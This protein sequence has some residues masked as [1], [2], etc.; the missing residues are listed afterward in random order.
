MNYRLLIKLFLLFI[1]I[2]GCVVPYYPEITDK[3]EMI[4]IQGLITDQPGINTVKISKSNPLWSRESIKYFSGFKVWITDDEG[5]I[6]SLKETPREGIY[7]T[8]PARFTGIP[9]RTY[10]LH[11]KSNGYFGRRNYESLPMKMNPSPPVDS[12]YY[13]KENFDLGYRVVEGCRIYLSTHDQND[14]CKY[15][16]W[17]Y[18][19]TWEFHLPFDVT[20]KI[21][22]ITADSKRILIK[23]AAILQENRFTGFPLITIGNPV[24]KLTV[25]YSLL[26]NQFSLNEDEYI[27]WERFRNLTEQTGGLYDIIPAPVPNNIFCVEDPAEK[28]LGYFSV[29]SVTSKRI[30]IKDNF[31]GINYMYNKCLEKTILSTNPDTIPGL[32]LSIWIVQDNRNKVP[33]ANIVTFDKGCVDCT[34]RG[35]TVKPSFWDDDIK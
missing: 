13:V 22:W 34:T 9:G 20:N 7:V 31:T 4:V 1:F 15:Y 12:V 6:D 2:Y 14:L 21:C 24:D 10:I 17:N 8:D 3:E 30:F 25:K 19:E 28:T 33:P 32:G 23:N 18:T 27:Y 11:V 16:R 29:S 35:T 5:N 26:V